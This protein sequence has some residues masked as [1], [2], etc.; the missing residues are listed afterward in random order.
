[1][2]FAEVLPQYV[3]SNMIGS[4]IFKARLINES[5]HLVSA[6]NEKYFAMKIAM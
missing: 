6:F 1:M 4:A 2:V 5:Y 3:M